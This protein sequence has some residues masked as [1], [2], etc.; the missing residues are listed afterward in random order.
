MSTF[1]TA[2]AFTQIPNSTILMSSGGQ[3]K[4][5]GLI[6]MKKGKAQE[7]APTRP[8]G[9]L[10]ASDLFDEAPSPSA[11]K[12]SSSDEDSDDA[13][14]LFTH[15]LSTPYVYKANLGKTGKAQI[16]RGGWHRVVHQVTR[17]IC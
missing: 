11:E 17:S 9:S 16:D 10:T 4:K 3:K 7:S 12:S 13:R 5:F 6:Y 14:V 15:H 8:A 1:N 2:S